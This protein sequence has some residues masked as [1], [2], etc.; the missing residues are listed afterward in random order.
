MKFLRAEAPQFTVA[1][2]EALLAQHYGLRGQ[3][4]PLY[5]ERDQNFRLTD[6]RRKIPM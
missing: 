6:A 5:S 1:Q 4:K 3:L 2:V